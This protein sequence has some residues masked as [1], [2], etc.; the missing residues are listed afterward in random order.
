[1]Q[2]TYASLRVAWTSDSVF[3]RSGLTAPACVSCFR[4]FTRTWGYA[5][6]DGPLMAVTTS[7]SLF[8]VAAQIFGRFGREPEFFVPVAQILCPS[9]P[10]RS[11][12]S[13]QLLL[14]PEIACS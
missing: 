12:T 4:A 5:V 7:L 2:S 3:G 8:T 10:V 11:P 1:M 13:V 9:P 6:A 14:W